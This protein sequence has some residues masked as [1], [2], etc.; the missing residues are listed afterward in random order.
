MRL[1]SSKPVKVPNPTSMENFFLP[2]LFIY[3]LANYDVHH[4]LGKLSA[5][6]VE[7]NHKIWYGFSLTLFSLN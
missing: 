3:Q 1:L 2:D 4:V 6:R 7:K 5:L